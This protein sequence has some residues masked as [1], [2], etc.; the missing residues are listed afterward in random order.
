MNGSA[1]LAF[2]TGMQRPGL[3][4]AAGC[5][6]CLAI[7]VLIAWV[8]DPRAFAADPIGTMLQPFRNR[9]ISC[10]GGPGTHRAEENVQNLMTQVM[11]FEAISG[12]LPTNEEGLP[13]LV[14][15]PPGIGRWRQVMNSVPLDP[16]D[17][18]YEYRTPAIRSKDRFEIYSLGPD[19][20]VSEDDI[21]N[22]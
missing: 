13:A 6:A 3:A 15:R 16:W 7:V 8:D 18:A 17:R 19:G 12:R 4:I 20:V 9:T 22:W 11:L 14:A 10:G 2:S 5:A 21:G 1:L